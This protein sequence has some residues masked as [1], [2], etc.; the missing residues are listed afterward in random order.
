[1]CPGLKR[2]D[3]SDVQSGVGLCCKDG[4]FTVCADPAKWNEYPDDLRYCMNIHEGVH[5]REWPECAA[6]NEPPCKL[7]S[8]HESF[9]RWKQRECR[10]QWISALCYRTVA[11]NNPQSKKFIG[12]SMYFRTICPQRPWPQLE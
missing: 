5:R 7:V 11:A 12:D 9:E 10:A 8:R 1:M 4:G 3:G 2:S 6:C